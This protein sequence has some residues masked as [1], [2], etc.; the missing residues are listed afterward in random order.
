MSSILHFVWAS[1]VDFVLFVP[2]VV[3]GSVEDG[4]GARR[5]RISVDSPAPQHQRDHH[6]QQ[7]QQNA[8][9]TV[10]PIEEHGQSF[11]REHFFNKYQ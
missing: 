4:S 10:K 7:D 2:F 11:K 5:Q 9:C 6:Q 3:E 8:A 1:A